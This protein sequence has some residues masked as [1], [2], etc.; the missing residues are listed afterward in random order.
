[1]PL[2]APKSQFFVQTEIARFQILMLCVSLA[3]LCWI[4][5]LLTSSD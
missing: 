5:K 4:L 2:P 3:R 1:V